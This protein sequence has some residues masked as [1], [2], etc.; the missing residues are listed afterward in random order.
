[1]IIEGNHTSAEI[2][3]DNIEQT[4]LDWVKHQCDH[5]AFEG[6]HIVQMPD[7][8]TGNGRAHGGL[9]GL[10]GSG[11]ARGGHIRCLHGGGHG[12]DRKSYGI[13]DY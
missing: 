6:V 5:P 12:S 7:V 10:K 2:F 1:M 13:F 3:T 9:P 4:A 8:H 11:C